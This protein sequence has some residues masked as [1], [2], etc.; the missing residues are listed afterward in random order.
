MNEIFS[1]D[2]KGYLFFLKNGKCYLLIDYFQHTGLSGPKIFNKAKCLSG[3]QVLQIS[4]IVIRFS[5][6]TDVLVSFIKTKID[7]GSYEPLGNIE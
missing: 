4:L 3:I 1:F 2:I 7:E 6:K 5:L